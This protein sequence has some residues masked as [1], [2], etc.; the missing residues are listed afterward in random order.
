[1]MVPEAIERAPAEVK[2]TEAAD[3][4]MV[5]VPKCKAEVSVSVSAVTILAPAA[6]AAGVP[7]AWAITFEVKPA[8]TIAARMRNAFFIG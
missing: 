5:M 1:M 3:E 7:T 4:G 6:V 2:S 8:K